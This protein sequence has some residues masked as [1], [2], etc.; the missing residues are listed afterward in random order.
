[1][2]PRAHLSLSLYERQT[3]PDFRFSQRKFVTAVVSVCITQVMLVLAAVYASHYVYVTPASDSVFYTFML[4]VNRFGVIEELITL[5]IILTA[6][7]LYTLM[8]ISY[9]LCIT[10]KPWQR[11]TRMMRRATVII[12]LTGLA[13]SFTGMVSLR[14]EDETPAANVGVVIGRPHLE[15]VRPSR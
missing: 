6:W 14:K 11:A 10:H 2:R 13:M 15:L 1:M 7:L 5:A 3:V 4:R 9:K 12:P 8:N